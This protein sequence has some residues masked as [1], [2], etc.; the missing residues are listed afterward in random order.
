MYR[1]PKCDGHQIMTESDRQDVHAGKV[2]KRVRFMPKGGK[3]TR[4]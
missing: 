1:L 2:C 4:Q 3:V